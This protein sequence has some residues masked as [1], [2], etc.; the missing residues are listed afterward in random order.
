[1]FLHKLDSFINKQ[2]INNHRFVLRNDDINTKDDITRFDG[3]GN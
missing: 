3:T 1:M 2:G